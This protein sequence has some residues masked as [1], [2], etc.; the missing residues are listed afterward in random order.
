MTARNQNP[1]QPI[2]AGDSFSLAF[3]IKIVGPPIDLST[4]Q[5]Q[6]GIYVD[7]REGER[8]LFKTLGHGVRLEQ[9]GGVWTLYADFEKGETDGLVGEFYHEATVIPTD[10]TRHTIATG[11]VKFTNTRNDE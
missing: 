8:K 10:A 1:P 9:I 3:P 11:M 5:A 6:Y 2:S 4:A 7:N